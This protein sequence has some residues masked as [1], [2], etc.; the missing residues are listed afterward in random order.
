[1]GTTVGTLYFQ[2]YFSVD[3]CIGET[4]SLQSSVVDSRSQPH[5]CL[6]N[7]LQLQ[8]TQNLSSVQAR[9]QMCFPHLKQKN[10]H[11]NISNAIPV[12][13]QLILS[14][15]RKKILGS[16]YFLQ[17]NYEYLEPWLSHLVNSGIFI[18][19][20]DQ[21]ARVW[22]LHGITYNQASLQF[23]TKASQLKSFPC[24]HVIWVLLIYKPSLWL[25]TSDNW[26][27]CLIQYDWYC[28]TGSTS[29]VES[30]CV[31]LLKSFIVHTPLILFAKP[32]LS[33]QKKNCLFF[34]KN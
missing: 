32:M 9:M 24:T 1:M 2:W 12:L 13:Q 29:T 23:K 26:A 18:W 15:K 11:V 14:K 27:L 6:F 10:P 5:K 22:G 33:L 20:C 16:I 3:L 34:A 7:C 28:H 30:G 19:L 8:R 31:C 21:H 25:H 4:I 17:V